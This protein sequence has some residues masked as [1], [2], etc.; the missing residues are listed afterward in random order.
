MARPK[1]VV[2]KPKATA[3]RLPQDL[4]A[5]LQATADERGTSVNHLIVLAASYYLDRLPP[6]MPGD[7]SKAS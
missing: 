2:G 1:K 4:H 5:R 3:V 6:L 7:V